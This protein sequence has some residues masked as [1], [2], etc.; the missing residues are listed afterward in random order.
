MISNSQKKRVAFI[1]RVLV[2]NARVFRSKQ[3]LWLDGTQVSTP[4]MTIYNT[5]LVTRQQA[6]P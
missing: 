4:P 6:R 3:A 1:I 2:Y 5:T